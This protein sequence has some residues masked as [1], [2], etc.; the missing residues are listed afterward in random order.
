GEE[1]HV[2]GGQPG[3]EGGV[4]GGLGETAPLGGARHQA[5]VAEEDRAGAHGSAGEETLIG[6]DSASMIP[7]RDRAVAG[8]R[9][10]ARGGAAWPRGGRQ[11]GPTRASRTSSARTRS[12]AVSRRGSCRAGSWSTTSTASWTGSARSRR[13]GPRCRPARAASST[14]EAP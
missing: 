4:L 9:R 1:L 5:G 6:V 12:T 11:R 14:T 2:A 10:N 13:G 3:A 8:E 7:R